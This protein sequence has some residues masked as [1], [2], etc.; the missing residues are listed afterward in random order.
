[1]ARDP[2][3]RAITPSLRSLSSGPPTGVFRRIE[4]LTEQI[5]EVA[6][7]RTSS[8]PPEPCPD[9]D[10]APGGNTTVQGPDPPAEP[11]GPRPH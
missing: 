3:A 8:S 9:S 6:A 10:E 2:F 5:E 7:R 11:T 1:M 4:A